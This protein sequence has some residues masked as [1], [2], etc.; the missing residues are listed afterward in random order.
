V[1]RRV[2]VT[3]VA[4][5][6]GFS[7]LE[8]MVALLLSS[9][10]LL[11]FAHWLL[12]LRQQ[13]VARTER[14]RLQ[15]NTRHAVALLRADLSGLE[16][17]ATLLEAAEGGFWIPAADDCGPGWALAGQPPVELWHSVDDRGNSSMAVGASAPSCIR[18]GEVVAGTD[19]FA[20]RTLAV[21]PTQ[22]GG[23]YL[24]PLLPGLTYLLRG[25]EA[26]F[27]PT[28]VHGAQ[29]PRSGTELW[30]YDAALY[31][32][33]SHAIAPGD[34]LPTLCRR[35]L[36]RTVV[37][38]RMGS[39]ECLVEG[40]E[41]MRVRA[42]IDRD[43]DGVIDAYAAS[44]GAVDGFTARAL[45]IALLLRSPGA[46]PGHRDPGHYRLHGEPVITPRDQY[47]RTVVH[48]LLS[49]GSGRVDVAPVS[50]L[51]D[52]HDIPDLEGAGDD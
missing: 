48:V 24:E 4:A 52:V 28:L 45:R 26:G 22:L 34:G 25:T 19:M 10:L 11:A 41:A 51:T 17:A 23:A 5:L 14:A 31:F 30:R 6:R 38:P 16:G 12:G 39:A 13:E 2:A 49:L 9:V 37:P 40:V 3:G 8:L 35:R 29:L 20:A 33:R 47:L 32:V 15:E 27:A 7:L 43:G 36:T 21:L 1:K 46:V 42:G 50:A 18:A 44:L